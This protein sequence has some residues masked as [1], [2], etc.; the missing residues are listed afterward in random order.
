MQ[1]IVKNVKCALL[2]CLIIIIIKQT[3]ALELLGF[4]ARKTALAHLRPENINLQQS[5]GGE[6]K[7]ESVSG[8]GL[9]RVKSNGTST[10][11]QRRAKSV[12]K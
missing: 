9:L 4:N 12:E 2:R 5:R 11:T 3:Q 1:L 7:H 10:E 8:D 6:K